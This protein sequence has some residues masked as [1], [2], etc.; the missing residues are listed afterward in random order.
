MKNKLQYSFLSFF[1][2]FFMFSCNKNPK[3]NSEGNTTNATAI[4]TTISVA[5]FSKKIK[6][7]KNVVVLDVRT[8]QEYAQERLPNAVL[9]NMQEDNPKNGF[10]ANI[11]KMDKNKTYLLYCTVG[12]RSSKA[13]ETMGNA[14]FKQVFHL[15]GGIVDW[16][17]AGEKTTK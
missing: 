10:E 15:D 8:P 4:N 1:T 14:G 13:L 11:A 5:E 17:K 7:D 16:K 9:E 6:E 12:G 2:L 3:Q